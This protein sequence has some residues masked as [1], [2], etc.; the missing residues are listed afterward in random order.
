MEQQDSGNNSSSQRGFDPNVIYFDS[1]ESRSDTDD[2]DMDYD[3][4]DYSLDELEQQQ[5]QEM[6]PIQ[7]KNEIFRIQQAFQLYSFQKNH[8]ILHKNMSLWSQQYENIIQ[9]QM[10]AVQYNAAV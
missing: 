6:L 5:L 2:D 7:E 4:T 1:E 10:S 3:Y 8:E 9:K